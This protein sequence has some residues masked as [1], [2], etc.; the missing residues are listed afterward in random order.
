MPP[1]GKE[2]RV[3]GLSTRGPAVIEGVHGLVI[4]ALSQAC[5]AHLRVEAPGPVADS[6]DVRGVFICHEAVDCAEQAGLL[7]V[8]VRAAGTF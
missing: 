3:D 5:S 2:D 1:G 8:E 6:R 7:L 4:V